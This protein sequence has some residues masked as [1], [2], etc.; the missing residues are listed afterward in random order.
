M[1][2]PQV[3]EIVVEQ[4][5]QPGPLV[6]MVVRVDDRLAGIERLLDVSARANPA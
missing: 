2:G 4:V 1:A 6:E 3:G 5:A